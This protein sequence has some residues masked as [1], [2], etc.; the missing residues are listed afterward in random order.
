MKAKE[1][2]ELCVKWEANAYNIVDLNITQKMIQVPREDVQSD[3]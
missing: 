2:L 1:R 3:Y